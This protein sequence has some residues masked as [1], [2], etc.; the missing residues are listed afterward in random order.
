MSFTGHPLEGQVVATLAGGSTLNLDFY[1]GGAFQGLTRQDGSG[2]SLSYHGNGRTD[3]INR[4]DGNGTSFLQDLHFDTNLGVSTGFTVLDGDTAL[5]NKQVIPYTEGEYA[6]WPKDIIW[7]YPGCIEETETHTVTYQ[8]FDDQSAVETYGG[9]LAGFEVRRLIDP[10]S[11]DQFHVALYRDGVAVHQV[12]YGRTPGGALQS[13][14]TS[15]SADLVSNYQRDPVSGF[16]TGLTRA[17]IVETRVPDALGRTGTVST[18]GTAGDYVSDYGYTGRLR[19]TLAQSFPGENTRNWTFGYGAG[20]QLQTADSDQGDAF[21]YQH[22]LIGNRGGGVADGATN[23]YSVLALQGG[24]AYR[25]AGSAAPGSTVILEREGQAPLTLPVGAE[26]AFSAVIPAP[27]GSADPTTLDVTITATLPGAGDGGSDAV[28]KLVRTLVAPPDTSALVYGPHGALKQDWRWDYAWTPLGRLARMTTR[29]EA[30]AAGVEDIRLH[31]AY[32][33]RDRRICKVVEYRDGDTVNRTV[34]TRF[35]HDGWDLL[36]EFTTDTDNPGTEQSRYYTWGL[37]ID[38]TRDGAGGVGGLVAIHEDGATYL[39]VH[40]GSGN[41]VALLDDTGAELAR[42]HRGPFGEPLAESGQTHLCPFGFATHYTDAETGLVYFGY[43]YYSPQQGRWLSREPLGEFESQNLY[44][45]AGNDPVNSYDILGLQDVGGYFDATGLTADIQGVMEAL[46]GGWWTSDSACDSELIGA[47]GG[48]VSGGVTEVL[49]AGLV[50]FEEHPGQFSQMGRPVGQVIGA[51]YAAPTLVL[52]GGSA[53]TLIRGGVGA[54]NTGGRWIA[55]YG[56]HCART[57]WTNGWVRLGGYGLGGTLL[58]GDFYGLATSHDYRGEWV[59]VQQLTPYP[60]EDL[61]LAPKG[62]AMMVSDASTA[63]RRW[64]FDF[65]AFS[66]NTN[67]KLGVQLIPEPLY[68]VPPGLGRQGSITLDPRNIGFSQSTVSDVRV[69]RI[70][71]EIRT[72]DD[73]VASMRKDGW[74]GDPVDVVLMPDGVFTSMDN[75]RILA[76]RTAG[77]EVQANVRLITDLLTPDETI[78]FTEQ[79]NPIPSTWGEAILLRIQKQANEPAGAIRWPFESWGE[80]F[81]N[82]SIYDP[83]VK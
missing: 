45:Y 47:G 60:G 42:W 74:S 80:R 53:P 56:G 17:G 67:Q 21:D 50:P 11:G 10:E 40:D 29:P 39:P 32:D 3:S 64:D 72:F 35:L 68:A 28:A 75:T 37:D 25:V 83:E 73:L 27:E 19:T 41:I 69:D 5:M 36:G 15:Q 2:Y 44:A 57:A 31:F 48:G 7:T 34:T 59:T 13:F 26:G 30:V 23:Q 66:A 14:T 65:L 20:N 6:G 78:R 16:T 49:T 52:G 22:D 79:G 38:G 55:V 1:P 81:P 61:L 82:G 54:Y 33:D 51:V 46:F 43:R 4:F 12:D 71:G 24:R 58:A 63:V 8:Y 70:T 9:V 62:V 76:A 18:T 77:I